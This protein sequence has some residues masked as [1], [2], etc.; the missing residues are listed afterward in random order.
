MLNFQSLPKAARIS[1]TFYTS[2][3]PLWIT[4]RN[5]SGLWLHDDIKV[6]LGWHNVIMCHVRVCIKPFG[7]FID[8]TINI[9]HSFPYV[10][11]LNIPLYIFRT[12]T[13]FTISSLRV[14]VYAAVCTY[15][16]NSG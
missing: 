16:A 6:V 5:V 1:K 2:I 10:F 4:A 12:D 14:T 8:V 13:P 3:D 9:A 7:I 11:I 15:H